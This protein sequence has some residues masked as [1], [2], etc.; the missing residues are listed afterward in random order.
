MIEGGRL[1]ESDGSW[2]GEKGIGV[3]YISYMGDEEIGR[4]GIIFWVIFLVWVFGINNFW[5]GD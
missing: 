4:L 1:D 5:F 3:K 2:G